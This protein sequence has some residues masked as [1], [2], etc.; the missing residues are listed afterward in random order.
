M[1]SDPSADFAHRTFIPFADTFGDAFLQGRVVGVD[2]ER[3]A[4]LLEGGRVR[5]RTRLHFLFLTAGGGKE[6]HCVGMVLTGPTW[7]GVQEVKFTHLIVA[8]GT[9]GYF[10]GKFNTTAS[11]QSA[12]EAYNDLVKQVSRWTP[13]PQPH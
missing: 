4:V 5:T 12:V 3:Q 1:T 10:P 11:L 6:G 7:S 8:T 9:D 13:R 2:T